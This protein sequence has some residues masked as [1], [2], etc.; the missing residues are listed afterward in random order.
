MASR[1]NSMLRPL[2]RRLAKIQPSH[3]PILLVALGLSGAVYFGWQL[4]NPN[5]L[6]PISNNPV[7]TPAVVQTASPD[8]AKALPRSEPIRVRVAKLNI[9]S[10]LLSVGRETDGT[11]EVPARPDKVGWYQLAPTPGELGPAILVGHVDSPKGPA[12]FWRLR[13]L[14]P[15]DLV[16]VD[17][18]D[19]K[20]VKFKVDSVKQ[21][22]QKSFPTQEV[23]GNINYPGIRLITCGGVF[24]RQIRQYS[25]NTVVFGSL[26]VN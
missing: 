8:I 11:M 20:T 18:A 26:T 16:E 13:E 17:R 2:K 7:P 22:P 23:Y 1:L 5:Q 14:A 19:G 15:G 4:N 3:W 12:V 6:K 25:H 24:D 9:D 10:S 21:F